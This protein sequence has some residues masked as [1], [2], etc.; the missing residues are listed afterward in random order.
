MAPFDKE[1]YCCD[2]SFNDT[3]QQDAHSFVVPTATETKP[4]HTEVSKSDDAFLYYSNDEIRL[5]A[6]KLQKVP[7]T[8]RT[9]DIKERKTRLS[10]EVDP[11]LAMEDML[12][13]IFD[14]D[15]EFDM[16][17]LIVDFPSKDSSKADLLKQLLDI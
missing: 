9:S 8:V 17:D 6:M 1:T 5:K 11:L 7:E 3:P 2:S 13:D 10:Y 12:D 14:E 16:S 15:E 4:H